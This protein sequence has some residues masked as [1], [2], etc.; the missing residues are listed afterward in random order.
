[1]IKLKPK[2]KLIL[3]TKINLNLISKINLNKNQMIVLTKVMKILVEMED[4][5][6]LFG[7]L[8]MFNRLILRL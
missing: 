1:M 2:S 8:L 5:V 3:I 4:Q 6:K 7:E